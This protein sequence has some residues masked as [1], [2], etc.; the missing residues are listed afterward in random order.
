MEAKDTPLIMAD[1]NTPT[2][3][4]T[5]E[6]RA[7]VVP[8]PVVKESVEALIVLDVS[9]VALT[10]E[11][12][13]SPVTVAPFWALRLALKVASLLKMAGPCMVMPV[14]ALR[15]IESVRKVRAPPPCV[16]VPLSQKMR[17]SYP[18]LYPL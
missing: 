9:V 7:R 1:E 17:Q 2:D 16:P 14:L 10:E 3:A 18:A 15:V 4:V 13:R 6:E 12:V 8:T 11:A 5:E